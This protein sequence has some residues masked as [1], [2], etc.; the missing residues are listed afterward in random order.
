VALSLLTVSAATAATRYAAPGGTGKDPCANPARPCSVFTA[1]D[2][3]ARGTTIAAGDVVELAPGTYRAE[4]EGEF[5]YVP[6]VSLPAG[7]A[8]RGEPGKAK[9]VV[10]LP[11]GD[12]SDGAFYVPAGAE[13]ADVEIRNS[14]DTGSAIDVSGGTIDRVVAR[15]TA[16]S[17]PT[18][19]F[20]EGT[21]RSS[22]CINSGGGPAIGA[23]VAAKGVFEGVIRNSTLVATG[24]GSVG[25]E[26]IAHAFKRGMTVNVDAV[27]VLV[28][29]EEKDV[30]AWALPLNRGRGATV[31]VALRNSSYETVE[32]RAKAGGR[33]SVTRPGTNGNIT[34]TPLL[35]AGNLHQLPGSPTV[36]KGAVDGAGGAFDVDGQTWP[37]GGLPDIGA[38]ELG[39]PIPKGNPAPDAKLGKR[40]WKR[41]PRRVAEFTFG[42]S[43]PGSRYEC[44]LDRRPFRACA[45]PFRKEVGLGE[46]RFG[47]RALDPQGNVDRAPALFRWR[48]LPWRA[49][50]D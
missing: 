49:F 9:P 36:D 8:L 38:D 30:V 31:A 1:A 26:F 40:P 39:P 17:E 19:N 42:S 35:A 11:A 2:E 10:V 43:E 25:M 29:G 24:P 6:P 22:A 15:S 27:S 32:T 50:L 18:C 16:S 33:A 12:S 4:E 3:N 7:V 14:M 13:V 37:V 47:V 46:H 34:S 28:E 5:G 48:V 23:N 41:T 21:V 20:L 45:S 44:K